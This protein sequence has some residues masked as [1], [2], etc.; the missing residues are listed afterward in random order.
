[1]TRLLPFRLTRAVKTPYYFP[2]MRRLDG[3]ALKGFTPRLLG[4]LL[5][6]LFPAWAQVRVGATTAI[7]ADLVRQV[8]GDRV[9]V[10]QIVP[11]GA[12]PHAFEPTPSTIRNLGQAKALFANGLDLEPFLPRLLAAL[13][14]G[15]KV[16]ELGEEEEDLICEEDE[17]EHGH[18]DHDH[19]HGCNPHL[20]LDPTYAI[21][22]AERIA[23]TLGELDPQ[24]QAVFQRNLARFKAEVERRDRAFQACRLKGFKAI[25]THDALPYFAR[26]YGLEIVGVVFLGER[27]VG[28]RTFAELLERAKKEGVKLVLVEPGYQGQAV[29]TLSESLK[30][31][32]VLLY[33]DTLDDRVPTYLALLDHNLKALCQ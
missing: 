5:A 21:R 23:K 27:E 17:E 32:V 6:F 24:G 11:H 10:I 13:P 16:V 14:R 9:Q 26:R 19:H 1:M 28:S 3:V 31:R 4:L 29:K 20:W 15:A 33:T 18:G 22:Y 7:V 25:V 8:G 2:A 12:N 30:A